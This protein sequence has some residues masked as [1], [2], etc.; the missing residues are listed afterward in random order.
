[1]F[2]KATRQQGNKAT[3]HKGTKGKE[4]KRKAYRQKA[5]CESLCLRVFGVPKK[6]AIEFQNDERSVA[7]GD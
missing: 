6:S 1:M 4:A 2:K 3:R 7:T 5:L